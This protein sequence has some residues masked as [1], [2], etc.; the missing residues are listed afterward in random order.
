MT[1]GELEAAHKKDPED[2]DIAA[3]LAGEYSRRGKPAE[4]RKLVDAVLDKEKGHPAASLVKARLLQRDKDIAEMKT[5]LEEAAAANPED[6]ACFPPSAAFRLNSRNS[7]GQARFTRP[8]VLAAARIRKCW[9][10]W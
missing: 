6:G 5:V 4:A 3:R 7:T 2:L 8:F 9:R 1:F 10:R